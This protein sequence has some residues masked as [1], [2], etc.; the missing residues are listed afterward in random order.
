[1]R[2]PLGGVSWL[3]EVIVA[4]YS[5]VMVLSG[6]WSHLSVMGLVGATSGVVCW[7]RDW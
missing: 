6:G 2:I 3:S 7:S 5:V 4:V 1:M